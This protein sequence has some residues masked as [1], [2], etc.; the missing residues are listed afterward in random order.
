[1]EMRIDFQQFGGPV[2]TGRDRGEAARKKLKLD[3]VKIGD[4]V[5]V[6]IPST[7]YTVTSSFFL[8]LFGK[9]IR[10]L[11][12]DSFKTIFK[13]NMPSFLSESVEEW[14][15]RAARDRSNML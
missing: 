8:G 15:Y 5:T 3:R 12:L 6:E 1:M 10:D 9:S 14:L 13:F 11:G 2:F 4:T 7:T